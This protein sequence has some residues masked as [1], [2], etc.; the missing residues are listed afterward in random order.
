VRMSRARTADC[1]RRVGCRLHPSSSP[2]QS[3][4]LDSNRG[5][6][7]SRALLMAKAHR[8]MR[9]ISDVLA[10]DVDCIMQRG[11]V[12]MKSSSRPSSIARST[13]SL[14]GWGPFILAPQKK[15]SPVNRSPFA[16]HRCGGVGCPPTENVRQFSVSCALT[17]SAAGPEIAVAPVKS[18]F[19][20]L[21]SVP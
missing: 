19:L 10:D 9:S 18:A 17:G 7:S 12:S 14:S 13:N 11:V 20:A 6:A 1:L 21:C 4:R 5:G 3:E 16:G 8:V 15:I 2:H